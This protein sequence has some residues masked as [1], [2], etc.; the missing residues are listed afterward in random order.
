MPAAVLLVMFRAPRWLK[1][2][3]LFGPLFAIFVALLPMMAHKLR[4]AGLPDVAE[5]FDLQEFGLIAVPPAENAFELYSR[6]SHKLTLLSAPLDESY[7]TAVKVGWQAATP[8]LR[9][10]LERNREALALYRVGSARGE[11]VYYQPA[12][13]S[14]T[15]LLPVTQKLRDLAKLARLEAVRL[16]SEGDV[17]SAWGWYR[18]LLRSSRH[19]GQHGCM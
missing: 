7:A 10:W 8:E 16:E 17:A 18:V 14:I 1:F 19:S 6:A 3:A 13:M 5:P 11:A 9:D 2:L 4:L 12:E 15:T